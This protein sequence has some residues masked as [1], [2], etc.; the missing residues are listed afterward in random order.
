VKRGS[1]VLS[2]VEAGPGVRVIETHRTP[3]YIPGTSIQFSRKR[4]NFLDSKSFVKRFLKNHSVTGAHRSVT[5]ESAF[6][7]SAA[8]RR[9]LH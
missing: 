6:V 7:E 9:A 5:G 8:G 4:T 1:D 2:E 3:R